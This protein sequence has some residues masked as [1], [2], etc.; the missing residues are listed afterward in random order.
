[1]VHLGVALI[2]VRHERGGDDDRDSAAES[3]YAEGG[4]EGELDD[5]EM[6]G[7]EMEKEAMVRKERTGE[8]E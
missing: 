4:G 8:G 3:G 5:S 2:G 1:M 6:A 7:S